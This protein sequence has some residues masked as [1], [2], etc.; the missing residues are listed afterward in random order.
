[1]GSGPKLWFGYQDE[2]S[3]R[4]REKGGDFSKDTCREENFIQGR[5]FYPEKRAVLLIFSSCLANMSESHLRGQW[6]ITKTDYICSQG[7]D[8]SVWV[9][10]VLPRLPEWMM[11][12]DGT[13]GQVSMTNASLQIRC[14]RLWIDIG[15]G[16]VPTCLLST[17]ICKRNWTGPHLRSDSMTS[18]GSW[19]WWWWWGWW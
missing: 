17:Q 19:D 5:G 4:E 10:V 11:P 9:G 12:P 13:N 2:R 7:G 14:S 3:P 1:M 16:W 6:R 8:G 18:S 15:E